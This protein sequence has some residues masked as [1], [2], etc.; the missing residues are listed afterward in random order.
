MPH[1][2][3]NISGITYGTTAFD[4]RPDLALYIAKIASV[5]AMIEM[6]QGLLLGA[7]VG[8][9]PS[10][11]LAMFLSLNASASRDAALRGAAKERLST[12]ERNELETHL[13]AI[14]DAAGARNSAIHGLWG[15]H[16]DHKDAL[17]LADTRLLVRELAPHGASFPIVVFQ[18]PK[19]KKRPKMPKAWKE[20]DFITALQKII[21]ALDG[22]KKFSA[23]IDRKYRA[24]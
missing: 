2:I 23:S 6:Q 17:I 16:D 5:S 3:K 19:P 18:N 10:T 21:D 14:K 11:S 20:A 24:Q 12:A 22:L 13:S 15:Y 7:I 1:P 9:D 4:A 8:G